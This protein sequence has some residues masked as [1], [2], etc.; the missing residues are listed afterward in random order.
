MF[1]KYYKDANN[2]I[3]PSEEFINSVIENAHHKNIH[4]LSASEVN[5]EK[6]STL[7][8]QADK[9]SN[10]YFAHVRFS[11]LARKYSHEQSNQINVH[12]N[13]PPMMRRYTKYAA[14]IAAALVIVSAA[15]I[16]MPVWQSVENKDDGVI[17]EEFTINKSTPPNTAATPP[18]PAD[19]NV[20]EGA[21]TTPNVNPTRDSSDT[22]KHSYND[23]KDIDRAFAGSVRAAFPAL[24]GASAPT[25]KE[26]AKKQ[27][28]RKEKEEKRENIFASILPDI[29][30]TALSKNPEG[31]SAGKENG[32]SPE[33]TEELTSHAP[34]PTFDPAQF[35]LYMDIYNKFHDSSHTYNDSETATDSQDNSGH[36]GSASSSSSGANSSLGSAGGGHYEDSDS[37]HSKPDKKPGSSGTQGS[38]NGSHGGSHSSGNS[39]SAPDNSEGSGNDDS[40]GQSAPD[41]DNTSP[42][43]GAPDSSDSFPSPGVPDSSDSFPSPGAPDSSDSFPSAPDASAGSIYIPA[44]SG[45]WCEYRSDSSASFV[46]DSGAQITVDISYSGAADSSPS[47]SDSGDSISVSMT[48]DGM[49]ISIYAVGADM[50]SVEEVVDAIYSAI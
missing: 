28:E 1:R 41:D 2:D 47:Y 29:W 6:S 19:K 10:R 33:Q 3:K 9:A 15:V 31:V 12:V 50:S 4:S 43:P 37:A 32:N 46:N 48:V 13:R 23:S 34:K 8:P 49:R 35:A 16:S 20:V 11:K 44:P 7:I 21:V 45:Y 24:S 17:V 18:V 39:P 27:E 5:D 40:P 25:G 38:V 36:I 26:E 22:S 30:N 42:S 14:S